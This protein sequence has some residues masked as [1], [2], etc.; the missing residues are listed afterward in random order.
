M[1]PQRRCVARLAS[2]INS[3]GPSL[4]TRCRCPRVATIVFARAPGNP[5]PLSRVRSAGRGALG[6]A[7]GTRTALAYRRRKDRAMSR[8]LPRPSTRVWLALLFVAALVPPSIA[9]SAT[10]GERLSL[11]AEYYATAVSGYASCVATGDWN[12]DG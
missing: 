9:R 8:L 5:E 12:G 7:P 1:S 11:E 4:F 2:G 3:K 10:C 6:T